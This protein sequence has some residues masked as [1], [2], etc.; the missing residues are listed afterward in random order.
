T[1]Y[2]A[3][4][5]ISIGLM[6]E[7]E[8]A[9]LPRHG[10]K[11]DLPPHKVNYRANLHALKQLGAERIIAT[12]AVGSIN[13]SYN[14]GDFAIPV[15]LLDM[16]KSRAG[17]FFDASPVTHID[18][19]EPYCPEIRRILAECA[20]ESGVETRIDS[21]MV[22]TEGPRYETP[23]EIR[24]YHK[25]DGDIVGMTGAPEAFLARELELCYATL[26]FISNKAA[27]MQERLTHAEVLEVGRRVMPAMLKIIRQTIEKLPKERKC[28]CSRAIHQAQ[29]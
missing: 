22:A 16:T 11:H 24:M 4:P 28:S 1:P 29:A 12:N 14:A 19:S 15:D 17:T 9:F 3:A 2:G 26:C 23:A 27:G 25:L 13:T 5:P 10:P 18:V 7:N 21:I 20:N 8:V 6:G